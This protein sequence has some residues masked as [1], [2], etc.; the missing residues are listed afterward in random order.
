MKFTMT[1]RA[2]KQT[3]FRFFYECFDGESMK[4]SCR[5]LEVLDCFVSVMKLQCRETAIVST[6]RTRSSKKVY[7]N[8]SPLFSL[9]SVTNARLRSYLFDVFEMP[10]SKYF[11]MLKPPSPML[12]AINLG[13]E[14]VSLASLFVKTVTVPKMPLTYSFATVCAIL[15]FPSLNGFCMTL[16]AFFVGIDALSW[17]GNTVTCFNGETCVVF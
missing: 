12:F 14:F 8:L 17:H 16:L 3:L 1:I 11:R 9:G 6:T 4:R 10:S 2:E 5:Y 7:E 13:T 15:G